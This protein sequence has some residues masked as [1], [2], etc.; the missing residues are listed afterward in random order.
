MTH[1]IWKELEVYSLLTEC[2]GVQK[3][4][5]ISGNED[6]NANCNYFQPVYNTLLID[7]LFPPPFQMSP[8]E[9]S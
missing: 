7:N 2:R 3:E 6:K 1:I 8:N 4:N 5:L 9:E